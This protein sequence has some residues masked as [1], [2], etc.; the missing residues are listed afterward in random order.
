M[1]KILQSLKVGTKIRFDG[2]EGYIFGMYDEYLVMCVREIEDKGSRYGKRYVNVLIYPKDWEDIEI[3][4]DQYP[5]DHRNYQG[6]T[7]DHPGNDIL[8]PIEKR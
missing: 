1:K 7:D 6:K 8:P 5:T 3:E 4:P 2:D